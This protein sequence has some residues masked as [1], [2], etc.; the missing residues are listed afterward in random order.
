MLYSIAN[1]VSMGAEGRTTFP[2]LLPSPRPF[3]EQNMA[4]TLY[5]VLRIGHNCNEQFVFVTKLFAVLGLKSTL[6][7]FDG[8]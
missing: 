8:D 3:A 5:D 4:D 6:N 1:D 2:C 7:P